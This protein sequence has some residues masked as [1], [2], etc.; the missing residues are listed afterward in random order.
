[1]HLCKPSS[2][3]PY[4]GS[5]S[6]Q[7]RFKRIHLPQR[8]M[9]WR[10]MGAF[11]IATISCDVPVTKRMFVVALAGPISKPPLRCIGEDPHALPYLHCLPASTLEAGNFAAL[12][13]FMT[14]R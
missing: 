14:D 7:A 2:A 11:V 3:S 8:S 9:E 1:M 6:Q 13:P 10:R 5:D 4:G 12:H